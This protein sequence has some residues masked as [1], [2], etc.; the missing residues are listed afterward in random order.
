MQEP[1]NYAGD[2]LRLVGYIVYH[3][4][5]PVIEDQQMK[6]SHDRV[7]RIWEDEFH[8]SIDTDHR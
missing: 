7:N 4:P 6:D 8:N 5:W 1:V 2:C 3:N